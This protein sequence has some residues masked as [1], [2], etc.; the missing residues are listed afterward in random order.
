MRRAGRAPPTQGRD[1]KA[2]PRTLDGARVTVMGLGRFGGG[3]GVTKW[4]CAQGARVLLTDRADEAA[5][6]APLEQLAG[7]R[8]SGRVELRLGRHEAADFAGA[9]LVIANPAV[10]KPWEDPFLAAARGAGTPVTTEIRL[11]VDRLDRDRTVGITGSAGKSSTS[12][13][14]HLVLDEPAGAARLGGNIGGSLLGASGPAGQWTVLELSSAMLWW[15]GEGAALAGQQPWSPRVAVLTNLAPNHV[16]WH[17]TVAH[18]GRSKGAIRA[19]QR[20]G[21]AFVTLF[22]REQPEAAAECARAC[23]AWWAGAALPSDGELDALLASIDLPE[24][25]GEHQRRNAR[26]AVLAAEAAL[27]GAGERVDRAA[28]VSR[29]ARFR[30]LPHRLQYVGTHR[31][32]RCYN[33]S[34]STTPDATL[35]AV[36]A[37]PEPARIHLIVGGSD[38]QVDLSQVRDLAPRLAG[39]YAIGA[40]AGQL[41]PAPPAIDCGTLEVAV[42]AAAGRARDGDVLLLS[43]AC[44]SFGQ[45]RNYEHRGEAFTDLVRTL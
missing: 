10:P 8:T 28:L 44:A 3:L 38:K 29:L 7:E 13:M 22:D 15:L 16:D 41:A 21:D 31:G 34:K 45:F 5:L 36:A 33:D 35:L 11:A 40:T 32:M 9:D 12:T 42:R 1:M 27:H 23:G 4:L 37:F 20:P 24:V 2:F 6:A 19:G 39:L 17:G 14:V 26:L 25:P 30:A 18:Y 43:P